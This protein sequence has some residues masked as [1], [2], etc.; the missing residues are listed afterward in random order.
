MRRF[1]SPRPDR[2]HATTRRLTPALL[3]AVLLSSLV[4]CAPE[5]PVEPERIEPVEISG[6]P[7]SAMTADSDEVAADSGEE[8]LIGVLPGGFPE[9]LPLPTPASVVDF[10]TESDRFV[11]LRT[12]L[13]RDAAQSQLASRLDASGWAPAGDRWTRTKGRDRVVLRFETGDA[14][15]TLIRIEYGSR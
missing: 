5:A 2:S 11:V 13:S 14:G 7:T 4:A 6:G 9:S 15:Q 12:S 1:A 3:A 10:G 8:G